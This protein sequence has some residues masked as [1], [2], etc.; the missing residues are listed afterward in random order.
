MFPEPAV[1][2]DAE[3]YGLTLQVFFSNQQERGVCVVVSGSGVLCK[4]WKLFKQIACGKREFGFNG[5]LLLLL[6][7]WG[8]RR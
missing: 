7:F 8:T 5:L 3:C 6:F 4:V 2:D 1:T